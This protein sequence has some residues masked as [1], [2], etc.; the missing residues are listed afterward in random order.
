MKVNF[1]SA[2]ES[3][4]QT[5]M[6]QLGEQVKAETAFRKWLSEVED[7]D[8]IPPEQPKTRLPRYPIVWNE[9]WS[10][11]AKATALVGEQ[12]AGHAD[13]EHF[14]SISPKAYIPALTG[15]AA[16][17]A[18]ISCPLPDHEDRH[19]SCRVYESGWYCHSCNRG[20]DIF[21]LAGLVWDVD[22]RG[23]GFD[24]ICQRLADLFA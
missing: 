19:P 23:S 13:K 2:P 4:Q 3:I 17:G 9:H 14:E 7:D 6:A 8:P 16:E 15:V 11:R 1:A 21:T 5:F 10:R 22:P 12:L 18:R 24:E 20:G